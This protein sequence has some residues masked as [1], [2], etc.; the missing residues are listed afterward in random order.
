MSH[1]NPFWLGAACVVLGAF[2]SMAPSCWSFERPRPP[3]RP[4]APRPTRTY[5]NAAWNPLRAVFSEQ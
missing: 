4:E 5:A 2:L 3:S 1:T